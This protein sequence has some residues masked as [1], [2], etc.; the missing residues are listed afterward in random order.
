[1]R[2]TFRQPA[3]LVELYGI[4]PSGLARPD[5]SAATHRPHEAGGRAEPPR[6]DRTVA[7]LVAG[8]VRGPIAF[9]PQPQPGTP[10]GA[11]LPLYKRAADKVE[12]AVAVHLG[13][14]IDV[15]G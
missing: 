8:V 5:Q 15:V 12:A 4:K 3:Q 11:T 7:R 14:M 10:V 2:I 13:R 6:L 1:M 9:G